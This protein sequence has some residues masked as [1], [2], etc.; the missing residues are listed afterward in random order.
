MSLHHAQAGVL[1]TYAS[2]GELASPD[3]VLSFWFGAPVADEADLMT[4]IQRWFRGGPE[5]DEDIRRRFGPTVEAAMRPELDGWAVTA[6]GRLALVLL[7]DQ[8]T[9]SLY[10]NDRRAYAGDAHAQALSVE[11]FDRGIHR[12]LGFIEGMFLAMPMAHA[13]DLVLQERV[14]R[15]ATELDAQAPPEY[16]LMT[17]I[18]I[19]QTAKYLGVIRRFGR[20]PH[21]NAILGRASTPEEVEFLKTWAEVQP[22]KAVRHAL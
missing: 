13:E 12:E 5:M 14:V 9:R 18:G 15:L 22:P 19:E 10:R 16:R 6:H 20:F 8:M 1:S 17:T 7:L 3:D 4:R 21:R 11:A 2:S